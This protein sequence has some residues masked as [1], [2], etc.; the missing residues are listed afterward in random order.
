L[1]YQHKKFISNIKQ[2]KKI[3]TIKMNSNKN[4]QIIKTKNMK[5]YTLTANNSNTL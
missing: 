1:V 5:D 4:K 3:K 2:Q